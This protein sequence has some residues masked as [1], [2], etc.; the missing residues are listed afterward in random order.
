MADTPVSAAKAKKH[1][2]PTYP[3]INLQQAIK[4]T[5]EFYEKE[6]RNPAS[7]AA[8]V[9][10]WDYSAKSSGAL[11][12]AAA[13]KSFGLLDEPESTGGRTFQVS[14]LGLKIVADKRPESAER[15]A[16]IRE[17]ALRPR[18]H[19]EIW[20]KYNGRVPSDAELQYRLELFGRCE[21]GVPGDR[22]LVYRRFPE[23]KQHQ[24]LRHGFGRVLRAI[25]DPAT[26]PDGGLPDRAVPGYR[27]PT[28]ASS[29]E[30]LHRRRQTVLCCAAFNSGIANVGLRCVQ[31]P[32]I[33]WNCVDFNL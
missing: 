1:R 26:G 19:A 20:R 25:H 12:T 29:L 7:F 32:G 16:A 30:S 4:R 22:P 23:R 10:H 31:R 33:R 11:V 6:H 9:T 13:L 15:D 18:I 24:Q 2:S 17:A 8:A 14:A 27:L 3:G 28:I 5:A 21:V